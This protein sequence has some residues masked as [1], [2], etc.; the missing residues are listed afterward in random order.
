M[1]TPTL[2]A[3]PLSLLAPRDMQLQAARLSQEAFA[4]AFRFGAEGG[5]DE[6][7]RAALGRLV[8]GLSEWAAMAT[9]EAQLV[10]RVLLLT[11]IDQWGL[12]YSQIFGGAALGGVTALIGAL[13]EPIRVEDE[14]R[15]QDLFETIRSDEAAAFEFKVE[16]RRGLHLAL[17]HSMIA[18][19]DREEAFSILQ[20][21]GGMMAALVREMPTLG[22]RLIAD[23]LAL[24][25]IRC[26]SQSLAAQ[27]LA[28]ETTTE[29]FGALSRDLPEEVRQPTMQAAAES[30][31]AWQQAQRGMQH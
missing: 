30:V 1:N 10:R 25:Q 5:P 20:A 27:G 2:P 3:D 12:A 17:W 13:R 24:I 9:T 16:L 18:C 21:L 7:R 31:L 26:L 23:A 8:A 28:R 14:A 15:A 4:A 22:W 6:P 11:G 19:E 29:L